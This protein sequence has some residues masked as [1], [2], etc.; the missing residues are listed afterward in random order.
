[1]NNNGLN[2][3]SIRPIKMSKYHDD[4][5]NV[6]LY[7]VIG[8]D[9]LLSFKEC[10]S[11]IEGRACRFYTWK[12]NQIF[13]LWTF[14]SFNLFKADFNGFVCFEKLLCVQIFGE[15][16]ERCIGGLFITKY[17]FY[18][19]QSLVSNYLNGA[20]CLVYMKHFPNGCLSLLFNVFVTNVLYQCNFVC[21]CKTNI[22]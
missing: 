5:Y 3:L 20:C 2:W 17:Y 9:S 15:R 1:M 22:V 10:G 6:L 12:K 8:I 11:F 19:S 16:W 13:L 14:C 7:S 21:T 18:G 4:H